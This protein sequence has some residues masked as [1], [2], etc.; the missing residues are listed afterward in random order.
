MDVRPRLRRGSEKQGSVR[1]FLIADIRGYTT[2]TRERG[3][4]SAARLAKK[5]ADL[6]R[7]TVESRGGLVLELRG[8]EALAIFRD[9]DQAVRAGLEFQLTCIEETAQDPDLRLPVGVGIDTGEAIPVED[10]YRGKAINMA[11][12]LCSTAAAGQV[13]VTRA[14]AALCEG[15]EGVRFEDRGAIELKGFDRPVEVVEPVGPEPAAAV[16]RVHRPRMPIPPE[17]DSSTPMVDREHEMRWLRGTWRRAR[18]GAG[19][20]LFVSGPHGIGKTRLLAELA[21]SVHLDG[22]E[23]RHQGAGGT[24]TAVA[25]AEIERTGS[26]AAPSLVVIDDLDALG[27][28]VV[29]AL[30]RAADWVA[31]GPSLI[32]V[33]F[34]DADGR[35]ELEELVAAID[36]RGDA[37]RTLRP[38][39]ASS[40]GEIVRLYAGEDIE[41]APIE[42]MVRASSGVPSRVHEVASD[43]ARDVMSR[44]L[45]AAAEW[46][47]E[48]R[49]R[50]TAE[51]AFAN[52]AIQLRLGRLYGGAT[53]SSASAVSCP[54][55]GLASFDREDSALFFGRERLVGELAARTVGVGL[56]GVVGPSGSGK[57]SVVLAGLLPSLTARLLPGSERWH[58]V[59]IRPGEHPTQT[60]RAALENGSADRAVLVVDQFEELFTLTTSEVERKKFA[61]SLALAAD[62]P[63][64]NCVVVTIRA[65]YY[66]H[67]AAYPQ[68]AERLAANHVLVS[69]MT[70]EELHRVVELPARRVG[71]RVESSLADAIVA[72]VLEEPGALPLLSTTLVE[73]W[74]AREAGWLRLESYER[75]GGVEGAVARLAEA[76]FGQLQGEQR[77]AARS[78]LLRLSSEGD[79]GTAVRRRVPTSEF[80]R[81]PAVDAVLTRFTEDRL[82]TTSEGAVEVAHEA[83]IREWP[84]LRAWLEEDVQGRQIRRHITQAANHWEE[85]QRDPAELYRGTRLSVTLEWAAGH[86]R[87]L[88][89]RE[90]LFLAA[91]REASDREAERQRRTNRRL[92]GLLAGVATFLI[93]AL[94]AGSLA[95]AQRSRARDAASRAELAATISL[96]NSLGAQG[97]LQPRL[98][99]ALL[100]A[101][102]AV[103]LNL[104]DQTRS[105]LLATVMR[106]PQF[107]RELD[108]GDTGDRPQNVDLSPDARTLAVPF[109]NGFVDFFD[110]ATLRLL[111]T[112]TGMA[113]A[114][115]IFAHQRRLAVGIASGSRGDIQ[116]M[117]TG[118]FTKARLIPFDPNYEPYFVS[119][120]GFGFSP[121]DRTLLATFGATLTNTKADSV[122]DRYDVNTG[123][124]ISRT[125]VEHHLQLASMTS[126]DGSRLV[127]VDTGA[128]FVFDTQ[129]MR[130]V[131]HVLI[132]G[133][134]SIA[135]SSD[136]RTLALGEPDGAIRVIDLSAGRATLASGGN[137]KLVVGMA[138][139][140]D[141]ARLITAGDDG[142]VVVW[143]MTRRPPT[144]LA[145]LHGHGGAVHGAATDGNT[146]YTSSLDGTVFVWDLTGRQALGHQFRAGLGD[147][148]SQQFSGLPQPYFGLSPDG[149][150][151]AA[152][153]ANGD[154]VLTDLSVVPFRQ[155]RAI[156]ATGGTPVTWSSYTPDGRTLLAGSEDGKVLLIDPHTGTTR[157]LEGLHGPIQGVA[158]SPDSKLVSASDT[159]CDPLGGCVVHVTLW[160]AATERPVER[161]LAFSLTGF[162]FYAGPPAFSPDG[163]LLVVPLGSGTAEVLDVSSWTVAHTLEGAIDVAAFSPTGRLLATTGRDGLVRL[164]SASNW[165][166]V[167]SPFQ[168]SAGGGTSLSFDPTGELLVT[169]ATDSTVRLFDLRNVSQV[170]PFGPPSFPLTSIDEWN[171]AE[172]TRDGTAVIVMDSAGEAWIW[173]MLWQAW[174]AHACAVAGRQLSRTEWKEFMGGRPYAR[175]CP[176][177]PGQ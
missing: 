59:V 125:L 54:Y 142:L 42:S 156:R 113:G 10:G 126:A 67:C 71:L 88:N 79:G 115:V 62:D 32:A 69:P 46:L 24:G 63:E 96:A 140:P 80:D 159:A 23:V 74:H 163:R 2:F 137:T 52:N 99:R 36:S 65:D 160:S 146:V 53:A 95:L 48:G 38:L 44:R 89:Q 47:A 8:D 11:A 175:V 157:S 37:H 43:W 26:A 50:R 73:L 49:A 16:L 162:P 114:P 123:R 84:R 13:L 168:D 87:E 151:L 118:T 112:V 174:A 102:E 154:I 167:G 117:D 155:L 103:N 18:R 17:L 153:E 120:G 131:Q 147:H 116:L 135:L 5:F 143:D 132:A 92:R 122:V 170:I 40:V 172:F 104:S 158:A 134:R 91:S 56:L 106:S 110:S 22:G 20:L 176:I 86:G 27:A 136:G 83:L 149:R 7:E 169:G 82:L 70:A 61:D 148:I 109:N 101:R 105:D 138:F 121:D 177:M 33:L 129:T 93:I 152:P 173:P 35:P 76:S 164:W 107:V 171:S 81:T 29:D 98:D 124:L 12:R 78:I 64:R 94:I 58:Q 34:L 1:T 28:E 57:S 77:E 31:S 85:R 30:R 66:G 100:L 145:T 108:F 150:T 72:E 60:L 19:G 90:Q 133:S 15:L 3:D 14:A 68:L 141:G 9:T 39:D 139:T 41:E 6:V 21:S 25:I 165:S 45:S 119:G 130:V 127:V 111:G 128:T 97:L 4:A 75:S 55:K 166:E 161:E 51:L 144:V